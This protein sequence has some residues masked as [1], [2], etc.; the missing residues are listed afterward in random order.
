MSV[1]TLLESIMAKLSLLPEIKGYEFRLVY[2][3]DLMDSQLLPKR[4]AWE[5]RWRIAFQNYVAM[6]R[7]RDEL[8]M[9]VVHNPSTFLEPILG[10]VGECKAAQ[11]LTP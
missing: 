4:V 9:S 8:V 6:I 1:A 10:S 2:L 11:L 3:V 5:E 7:A